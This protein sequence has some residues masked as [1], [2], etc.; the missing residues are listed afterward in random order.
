MAKIIGIIEYEINE[1]DG[2]TSESLIE[3]VKKDFN[4]DIHDRCIN[5]DRLEWKMSK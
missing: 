5:A 3:E 1:D 4:Y 2:D